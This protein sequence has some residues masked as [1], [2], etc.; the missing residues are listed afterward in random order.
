MRKRIRKLWWKLHRAGGVDII[1]THAPPAGC[2]DGE[3]YAHRGFEALL[4]LLEKYK[5]RF[6]VHGHVHLNYGP[7]RPRVHHYGETTVINA[8]ER[9]ELEL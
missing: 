5:P 6:L 1:V 4:P 7:D 3:D 9:F 8:W 2:G